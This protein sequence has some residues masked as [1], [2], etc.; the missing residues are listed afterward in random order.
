[1]NNI[2]KNIYIAAVFTITCIS[3]AGCKAG[4]GAAIPIAGALDTAIAPIQLIGYAGKGLV[5]M[6]D[7]HAERVYEENKN[8][9]TLPFDELTALVYYIPGYCLLPFNSIAP[10]ELYP[11]TKSCL[12]TINAKPEKERKIR[13]RKTRK[14][15]IDDFEEF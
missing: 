9:V 7:D 3:L 5:N 13:T 12:N 6:G 10:E 8:S 1:M 14:M 11:L 4:A 2:Q 15:P